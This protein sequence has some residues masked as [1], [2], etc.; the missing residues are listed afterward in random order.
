MKQKRF[1][2]EFGIAEEQAKQL[3]AT[4]NA[5]LFEVLVKSSGLESAKIIAKTLLNTIP[6]LNNN[7]VP[8]ENIEQQ[9]LEEL[10]KKLGEDVFAKEAIPEILSICSKE[11]VDIPAAVERLGIESVDTTFV[12][13]VIASILAEPERQTF[14]R[15]RGK[16]AMGLGIP[17][18][19]LPSPTNAVAVTVPSTSSSVE[20]VVVPMPTFPST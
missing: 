18:N 5:E 10:F 6:E 20:G 4:N 11:G 1:G 16:A 15:E 13:D 2:A 12:E 7:G 17:V 8:I 19:P 14:I 3:I 9:L